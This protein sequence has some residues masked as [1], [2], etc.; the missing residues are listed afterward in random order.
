MGLVLKSQGIMAA[1]PDLGYLADDLYSDVAHAFSVRNLVSTRTGPVMR[2][3]RSSDAAERDITEAQIYDGTL[4]G[5][6]GAEDVTVILFYNQAGGYAMDTAVV[7]RQPKVVTAGQLN[8]QKGRLALKFDGV[9]DYLGIRT[10]IPQPF[11]VF[12]HG[13]ASTKG[14]Y[15]YAMEARDVGQPQ[16]VDAHTVSL[17]TQVPGLNGADNAQDF[18]TG[19]DIAG[20][21]ALAAG[22]Q[23]NYVGQARGDGTGYFRNKLGD[24]NNGQVGPYGLGTI[25]VG[26]N[27]F[28]NPATFADINL[29]E[30]IVFSSA[31][32]DAKSDEIYRRARSYFGA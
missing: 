2:I 17:L 27:Q 12:I 6:A 30:L 9:D 5:F 26:C 16:G 28:F 1:S 19:K 23:F 10:E 8:L 11:T 32:S 25:I 22:S 13:Y 14:G 29:Q 15:A 3:R 20:G 7:A 24:R 31:I 18:Y 21:P 4:L